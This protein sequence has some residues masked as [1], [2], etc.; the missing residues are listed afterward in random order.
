MI[1]REGMSFADL[2]G[3]SAPP[4]P[5]PHRHRGFRRRFRRPYAYP[6]Y[7]ESYQPVYVEE[8]Q[9]RYVIVDPTGKGIAVVAKVGPLPSGWTFRVATPAEAATG[10]PV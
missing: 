5:R 6:Y 10:V 2:D 9:E 3:L 7:Y 1:V 4:P 8:P